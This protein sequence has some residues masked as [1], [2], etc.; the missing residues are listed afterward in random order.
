MGTESNKA[1]VLRVFDEIFNQG[2]VSS[3]RG[4]FLC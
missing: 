4:D 3:R 1:V 2:D